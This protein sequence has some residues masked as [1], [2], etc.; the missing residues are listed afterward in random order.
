MSELVQI[1]CQDTTATPSIRDTDPNLSH[2]F[3]SHMFLE[4]L[5]VTSEMTSPS[6]GHI[7]F[8]IF[9]GLGKFML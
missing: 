8:K 5:L 3:K 4:K 9:E 6:S 7:N 2:I 1:V